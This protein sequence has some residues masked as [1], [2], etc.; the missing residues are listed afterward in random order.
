MRTILLIIIYG[1]ILMS[2]KI[3]QSPVETKKITQDSI[4][5]KK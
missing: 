3:S 1:V 5:I 2:A 4:Y